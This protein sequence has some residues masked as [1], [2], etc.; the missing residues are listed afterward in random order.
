MVQYADTKYTLWIHASTGETIARY[1]V[2]FGMDIHN[3][4]ANQKKNKPQCLMCTHGKSD[5]AEFDK[6]CEKVKKL[7]GVVIDKSKIQH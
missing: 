3:T 4:I 2:L 5:R 1:S 7:W 6:F